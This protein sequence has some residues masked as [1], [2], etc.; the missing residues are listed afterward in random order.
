MNRLACAALL[1]VAGASALTA[2]TPRRNGLGMSFSLSGPGSFASIL[3]PINIAPR[4]RLEP[5]LTFNKSETDQ[6][7]TRIEARTIGVAV[8]LLFFLPDRDATRIYLGPRVGTMMTKAQF[9]DP[10][11]GSGESDRWDCYGR[12]VAGGEH[13]FSPHFSIGGEARLTYFRAGDPD[14]T[15]ITLTATDSYGTGAAAFIRWYF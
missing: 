6:G 14:G 5:E 9:S 1:T 4:R 2:Q 13:M 12:F 8:G 3:V 7:T 15:G 11:G 10:F